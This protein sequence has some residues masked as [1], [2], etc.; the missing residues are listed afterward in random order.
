MSL[1]TTIPLPLVLHHSEQNYLSE[2]IQL[3]EY[4]EDVYHLDIGS[5]RE[6]LHDSHED[7]G[8]D[9]H[10]GQVYAECG[11]KEVGFEESGGIC[12]QHE[13]HRRQV[14]SSSRS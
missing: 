3:P 5:C 14:W 11:L 12:R 10:G 2:W 8:H 9:Q 13:Q 6:H 4:Q 1:S 7:G